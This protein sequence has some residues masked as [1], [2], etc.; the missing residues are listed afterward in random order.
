M[1]KFDS[2]NTQCVGSNYF[3]D[4]EKAKA[5][6]LLAAGYWV[7]F[8]ANCIGHTRA[9]MYERDGERYVRGK[10]GDDAIDTHRSEYG[11]WYF[12]LRAVKGA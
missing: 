4:R 2:N 3:G 6:E 12:R 10:Y 1:A 11:T 7:C 5:D 8:V 9:A